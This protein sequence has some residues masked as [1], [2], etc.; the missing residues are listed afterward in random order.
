MSSSNHLSRL[1]GLCLS[2]VALASAAGAAPA[3][4]LE[5]SLG[6]VCVAMGSVSMPTPSQPG[7]IVAIALDERSGKR[8]VLEAKLDSL[9]PGLFDESHRVA[10]GALRGRLREVAIGGV[11]DDAAPL[12]EAYVEGMWRLEKNLRGVCEASI[13][14]LDGAG[15]RVLAGRLQGAL[16]VSGADTQAIL[17]AHHK[18]ARYAAEAALAARLEAAKKS[19]GLGLSTAKL[20]QSASSAGLGDR[21]SSGSGRLLG[22]FRARILLRD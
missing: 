22:E 9:V 5:P 17:A 16:D 3:S 4:E 10:L 7:M 20:A 8:Y 14:K 21:S 15:E 2:S 6:R 18:R 12:L 11:L 19:K 13:W 1:L